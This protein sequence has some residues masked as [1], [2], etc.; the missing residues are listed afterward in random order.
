MDCPACPGSPLEEKEPSTGLVVD[1]CASCG[2]A[3]LDAGELSRFVTQAAG[4]KDE[5]ARACQTGVVVSTNCP[6]C[7]KS[8]ARTRLA[9]SQLDLEVCPACQGTWFERADL[10]GLREF[11]ARKSALATAA[12]PAGPPKTAPGSATRAVALVLG[13]TA[14]GWLFRRAAPPRTLATPL[15]QAAP[16]AQEP[17]PATRPGP[18]A[19]PARDNREAPSQAETEAVRIEQDLEKEA[20]ARTRK[21]LAA[22]ALDRTEEADL[23]F[24]AAARLF[25][26]AVVAAAPR[27]PAEAWR[28]EVDYAKAGRAVADSAARRRQFAE[29][30]RIQ[31]IRLDIFERH[32]DA[33][34]QALAW[35][36]LGE[37][38]KA[39]ERY[40][41]AADRFDK[42]AYFYRQ[43][44]DIQSANACE[45]EA[46]SAR[47]E[48]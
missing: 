34:G 3:W 16:I 23:E 38:S 39:D 22:K 41:E 37:A 21:A 7:L 15:P 11:L 24:E 18:V 2:G 20:R 43:A 46:L 1:L 6:R 14:A 19:A 25:H 32:G 35:Q 45:Q 28:L 33:G 9:E 30:E 27:A 17:A 42:A 31:K 12:A 36:G 47:R 4:L 5:L 26:A 48:R 44:K 40:G 8:M 29:V 10:Q 13:V